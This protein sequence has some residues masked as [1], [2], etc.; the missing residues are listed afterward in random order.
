MKETEDRV[1]KDMQMRKEKRVT[2]HTREVL[3]GGK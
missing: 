3:V 2:K 1:R